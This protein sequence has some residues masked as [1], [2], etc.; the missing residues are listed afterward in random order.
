MRTYVAALI[1]AVLSL[2]RAA[3]AREPSHFVGSR[4]TRSCH[5]DRYSDPHYTGYATRTAPYRGGRAT[6]Y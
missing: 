3:E 5:C 2:S 4:S 1:V 6:R